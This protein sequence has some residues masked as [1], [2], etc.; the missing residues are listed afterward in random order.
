MK[1]TSFLIVL[2][3]SILWAFV[4]TAPIRKNLARQVEKDYQSTDKILNDGAESSVNPLI[5]EGKVYNNSEYYKEY[6]QKN[7]ERLIEKS[8]NY[9][10]QNKEKIAEQKRKYNIKNKEKNN[11]SKRVYYQKN[12]EKFKNRRKIY[13]QNNK[14]KENEYMRKYRQNKKNVQSENNE[15][16]SFV[17]PQTG[18]FINKDKLPIC[19]DEGNFINQEKEE[20]NNGEDRENQIEVEEPNKIPEDDTN[21]KEL[22]KKICSFDLNEMP[23]DEELEDY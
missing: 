8:R 4:K 21:N 6:Y 16:T 19:E 2:I 9:R 7:K 14:E 23:D 15:G 3:C 5:N 1:F 12:K 22:N 11:N 18:D 17:N 10:K 20:S 13:Y